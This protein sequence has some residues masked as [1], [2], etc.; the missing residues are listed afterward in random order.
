MLQQ[1]SEEYKDRTLR[2]D[3]YLIGKLG[4]VKN[5]IHL[6]I[7]DY[8]ISC[9]PFDLSLSRGRV[10][11]ILGTKE[12]SFFGKYRDKAQSLHLSINNSA[13]SK[14]ISI[15]LK[16][17][18]GELKQHNPDTNVCVI[19]LDFLTVP[20][21]FKEMF[22]AV[23]EELDQYSEIYENADAG[24]KSFDMELF[25]KSGSN[26]Y[27]GIGKPGEQSA[28]QAKLLALHPNRLTVFGDMEGRDLA[29]DEE[30]ELS[31]EKDSRDIYLKGTVQEVKPSEEADGFA[32]VD[33]Q[34]EY[35]PA[36]VEALSPYLFDRSEE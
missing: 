36:F 14:P 35:S 23:V 26:R 8:L 22:V 7:D 20:N 15:Y 2:L 16:V 18:L 11:S 32:T 28:V 33:F 10:I 24:A 27:I 1:K 13:F 4:L 3:Q 29:K 30:V 31:Y 34:L 12:I 5:K 17:K 9:V 6:K 25:K 21:D 19:D